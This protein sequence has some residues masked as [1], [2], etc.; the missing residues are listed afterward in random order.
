VLEYSILKPEGILLLTPTAPLSKG[1]FAGLGALVDG[2]LASHTN[3]H[4]VL[5]HSESFSG[6][7]SFGGFT[8]HVRF[9]REHERKIDRVALVTDSPVAGAARA[10]SRLFMSADIRHFAIADYK[11]ALTWLKA[12]REG[13]NRAADRKAGGPSVASGHDAAWG[14]R[15]VGDDRPLGLLR[16]GR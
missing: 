4:G 6:W 11:A 5:V 2:Y 8:A 10:M 1:D 15:F 3:L 14:A 12:P 16:V 9:L 7:D 13:L